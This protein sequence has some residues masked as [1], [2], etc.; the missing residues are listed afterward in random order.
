MLQSGEIYLDGAATSIKSVE[1]AT[2]HAD[3]IIKYGFNPLSSHP[4]LV[5]LQESLLKSRERLLSY[6]NLSPFD[7]S[8]QQIDFDSPHQ[9]HILS[10]YQKVALKIHTVILPL[11]FRKLSFAY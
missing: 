9:Y 10:T 8:V 1:M 6:F 4:A 2:K 3:N 7:F 11:S 5:F